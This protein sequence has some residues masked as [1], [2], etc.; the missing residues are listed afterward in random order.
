MIVTNQAVGVWKGMGQQAGEIVAGRP[1]VHL[2]ETKPD[3]QRAILNRQLDVDAGA[4]RFSGL[5]TP[6]QGLVQ[7][8]EVDGECV[9]DL[10]THVVADR[11]GLRLTAQR[12]PHGV[13]PVSPD[14]DRGVE[15]GVSG[16]PA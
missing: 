13:R 2:V 12:S 14:H 4:G 6:P 1:S 9:E 5:A 3:V 8:S 10:L 7:R 11:G 16:H 15:S